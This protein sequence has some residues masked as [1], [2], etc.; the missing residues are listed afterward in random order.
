MYFARFTR[1]KNE[2]DFCTQY[3]SNQVIVSMKLYNNNGELVMENS[4]DT[5]KGKGRLLGSAENSVNIGTTN[6]V[7]NLV[8]ALKSRNKLTAQQ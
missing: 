3:F 4:F 1:F 8:A 7:R 2:A 5:Y 6:V